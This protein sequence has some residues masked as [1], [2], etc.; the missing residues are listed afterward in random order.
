VDG[1]PTERADDAAAAAGA[2]EGECGEAAGG[3]G[4]HSVASS[5]SSVQSRRLEE[6]LG[7][8]GGQEAGKGAELVA[9][10]LEQALQV[11]TAAVGG[12]G[13][14]ATELR[15]PAFQGG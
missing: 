13:C 10:E 14:G 7:R 3:K 4:S 8:S 6:V 5:G 2:A 9:A 15:A 12:P 11:G 1:G